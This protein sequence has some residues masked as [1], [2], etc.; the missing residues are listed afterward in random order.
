MLEFRHEAA[1]GGILPA[2]R[3]YSKC[4]EVYEDLDRP[5]QLDSTFG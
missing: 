5:L 2:P 4:D 3:Q 1:K